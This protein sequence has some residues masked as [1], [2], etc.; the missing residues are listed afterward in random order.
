MPALIIHGHFYQPPRENPWTG[1]VEEQPS[2][3]PH[4]D[5]NERVHDE[6]YRPNAFS[7]TK[8]PATEEE[9]TVNN[10]AN[11]SFNVGPTLLSW[12]EQNHGD[13]YDQIIE[14]DRE[15]RS[16][17][18]GHG[19]AIAQAYGHA[20]LPLCNDR[21]LRT[22]IRWGI[23]DF[24]FRFGREPEALWLPE[25]ACNDRVMGALIEEGLRF[26]ILAPHQAVRT[27][28]G[29]GLPS[30]Q[31]ASGGG[32]D[33]V[34]EWHDVDEHSLD[35]SATYQYLHRDGSGRSIAVFFYDG[36]T[37]RAMAFENL[38]RSSTELVDRLMRTA[39][40]KPMI[41]LATDGE[42]YGHHFKF[43]DLCLAH[44][45]EYEAHARGFRVTNYGE[46]LDGHPPAFEIEIN[47]ELDG[48]GTSWSC[49]HGIGRWLRDCGCQTG[50][51]PDWNQ[52]W[53]AP[54]RQALDF[55]RD[56]DAGWFEATRGELF[57]D[58]WLTRDESI[59]L[60]LD[61]KHSRE[62]FLFEH[63]GR[64]LTAD[65]QWRALTYLEI[66][67]ML[68][69]MYT[70]CGWFFNDISGIETIQVLRY[71]GRAIDLMEQLGLPT[72]KDRFLKILEESKSNRPEMGS[73]A[74][75]FRQFVEPLKV[76]R[77]KETVGDGSGC[78]T[79]EAFDGVAR[80]GVR[81]ADDR[82]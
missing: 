4:H 56:E 30:G 74:D 21:D 75:I 60:I 35:T 62:Q 73:G 10:Y 38:L 16:K 11:I 40:D 55:L 72:V 2:A 64:W 14:A 28:S 17:H 79:P 32:C 36:P 37:S 50:G 9:R 6:C 70:S 33:A 53:R 57:N 69:L 7:S 8:D 18:S 59:A 34:G 31:P 68:L 23:A 19:N 44:A 12:L 39:N 43:G 5:W 15:S 71:A 67:R 25:T 51:A 66:Q 82:V 45:L 1:M 81:E 63:A 80:Q 76:R 27:R 42:S 61:P 29:P 24:R 26:V 20:I 3:A 58:P 54:L 65:E 13:T 47:N 48:Q 41:N 22:Q 52:Q 49:S 46:Y 77:A 78:P